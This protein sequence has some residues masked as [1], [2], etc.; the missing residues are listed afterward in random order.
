M[1]AKWVSVDFKESGEGA[2]G[3]RNSPLRCL[4]PMGSE[5]IIKKFTSLGFSGLHS[6]KLPEG[7]LY[8]PHQRR[9]K[10]VGVLLQL[11]AFDLPH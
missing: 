4:K 10:L 6:V 11:G 8:T 3:G 9:D 1:G 2:G 5:S 7:T